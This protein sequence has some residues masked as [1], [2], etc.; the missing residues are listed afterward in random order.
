MQK[1]IKFIK[2]KSNNG[3]TLVTAIVV[4]AFMS[5]LGT[6]AL[7]IAGEN[8]KMK[9]IDSSNKKSFYEAEQVVEV[10]KAQLSLDVMTAAQRATKAAGASF[11]EQDSVEMREQFYLQNFKSEFESVWNS[12]WNDKSGVPGADPINKDQAIGELFNRATYNVSAVT[13]DGNKCSFTMEING[14]VLTCE[15]NDLTNTFTYKDSFE[16][17]VTL[18]EPSKIDPSRNTPSSYKI[19]DFNITVTN[20]KGYVSVINTS[21]LITPPSLNWDSSTS[22]TGSDP[23]DGGI[24]SKADY[25]DC[26][27][28]LKWSKG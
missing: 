7:F 12:H 21:F 8:Y 15:I 5:I 11:V 24:I 26:V 22:L 10:L 20:D 2:E 1:L 4:V 27:L 28:Y 13:V 6:I 16:A 17:P 25:S 19:N 18:L 23:E 3:S 14:Q 9:I